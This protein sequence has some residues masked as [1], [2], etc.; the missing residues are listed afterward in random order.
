MRIVSSVVVGLGLVAPAFA[1]EP[2]LSD[3]VLVAIALQRECSFAIQP[4]MYPRYEQVI[5]DR[6]G[7]ANPEPAFAETRQRFRTMSP[8]DQFL[9]CHG[10][11]DFVIRDLNAEADYRARRGW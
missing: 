3:K 4:L 7:S 11:R 8:D 9:L 2:S 1:V 10:L 6:F 5:R